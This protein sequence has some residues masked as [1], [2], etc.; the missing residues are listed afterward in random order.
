MIPAVNSV[1]MGIFLGEVAKRHQ[2]KTI[3]MFLDQ[4]GW[5]IAKD[6]NPPDNI[7]LIS[8]PAYSPEL[9]PVEHI[10]DELREKWFHNITFDSITSVEDRL[11]E[12]LSG[13]ENNQHL[14]QSLTGFNW[15]I[16][17]V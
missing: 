10:W 3:F 4:A 7:K 2:D 9:N 6:L 11:V 15:I 14:V 8:L 17:C 13:L 12:G 5:H 1:A 16:S